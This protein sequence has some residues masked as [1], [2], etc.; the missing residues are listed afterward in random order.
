MAYMN[1][2]EIHRPNFWGSLLDRI[3]AD[4]EKDQN[5][6]EVGTGVA[7]GSKYVTTTRLRRNSNAQWC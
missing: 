3:I 5:M 2:L 4:I 6:N 7:L 1:L